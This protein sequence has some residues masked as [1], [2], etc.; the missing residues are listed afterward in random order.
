MTTPALEQDIQKSSRSLWFGF[1]AGPAVYSLHFLTVYLLS[2]VACQS[3]WL[4]VSWLGLNAMVVV[5][6]VITLAAALLN[7]Y[8][9]WLT[10]RNWQRLNAEPD[11]TAGSYPDFMALVGTW[12]NLLFTVTILVTGL[13]ALFLRPC[14]WN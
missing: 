12:L 8:L 7:G 10:Y 14:A 4:Q 1:L 6:V 9:G 13:P 5:V 2:E 11:G 3:N